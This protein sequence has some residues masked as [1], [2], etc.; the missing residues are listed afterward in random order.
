M[1]LCAP[2]PLVM[3]LDASNT[4][5][6]AFGDDVGGAEVP[7]EVLAVF[8]AAERDDPFRAEFTGSQYAEQADGSVAD[9]GDG[10]AGS[11]LGGDG[12]EPAGAE[13]VRGGEQRWHVL[14]VGD[15]GRRDE[16]A[17]GQ[18]DAGVLGL[19]SDRSDEFGVDAAGLVAGLADLAG[20]VGGE[21]RADDELAGRER[22]HVAADFLDDADV[23]V[24]HRRGTVH[25]LDAAV[26]PQVRPAHAGGG[27]LDDRVGRLLDPRVRSGV[28][29]YVARRMQDCSMHELSPSVQGFAVGADVS[30]GR[31]RMGCGLRRGRR[32]A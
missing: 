31:R 1:T 17:V 5:I 27:E 15:L 28:Q 8:V 21:E 24:P 2:Y 13:H 26:G 14:V 10:L 7:G 22:A 23:L 20:V 12:R 3:L 11:C 9:D 18:R 32:A 29:A 30:R 16:G 25:R 6:A 19:G 4:L